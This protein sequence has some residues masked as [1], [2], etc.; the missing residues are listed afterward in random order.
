MP[1]IETREIMAS[2]ISVDD[3][4]V[5]RNGAHR[6][7]AEVKAGPKWT[8]VRDADGALIG[9]FGSESPIATI[10]S[11]LTA[12]E[13][14]AQEAECTAATRRINSDTIGRWVTDQID[15]NSDR[16]AGHAA[17]LAV[18]PRYHVI[19]DIIV[20][21]A[22]VKLAGELW[23]MKD[24]DGDWV[25]AYEVWSAESREKLVSGY[26]IRALSRSTSTVSNLMEDVENELRVKLLNAM[27][28]TFF[29][30]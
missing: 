11:V 25:S 24:E 14:A 26:S 18:T 30:F 12:E 4:V 15:G 19:E 28:G 8:T 5:D 23:L 6:T 2:D 3:V 10:V 7:V 17:R 22:K 29:R 9:R 27:A 21:T 20:D 1:T 16:V 13:L